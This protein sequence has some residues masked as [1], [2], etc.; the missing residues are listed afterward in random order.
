MRIIRAVLLVLSFTATTASTV[1]AQSTPPNF[2]VEFEEQF[3]ASAE[4]L[5]ALSKV[6]PESTYEWTPMEGVA[7]VARVYMHIA[8]YNY[9]YP[10][11]M[12]VDS[13][14][15]A[16]VYETWE[17]GV[18]DKAEVVGILEASMAHVRR[19]ADKMGATGMERET[20][21]Y[22]RD[23]GQWAVLFQLITHMN[24]HLGQSIA[25]ARMNHAVPP[26]SM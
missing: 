7:S 2:L 11:R 8:R 22:G 6:M 26:W 3:N 18:T 14:M 12:G 24:E 9:A 25:Y 10:E 23:V 17:E 13:P 4:K 20:E 15:G 21:L 1:L 16:S 19:V 5:V